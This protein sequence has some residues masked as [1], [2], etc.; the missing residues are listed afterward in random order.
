MGSLTERYS[1]GERRPLAG[2]G[3]L[4][5]AY[6]AC[7]AGGGALVRGRGRP[8]PERPS[9]PDLLLATIATHLASRLLAKDSVMAVVRSPFTRYERAT[10]EGEVQES[11]PGG[12]SVSHALGEL[13]TCPFCLAM[14]IATAV[15]FGLLLAPR[16]T[17]WAAATLCVAA[18][19]DYLQFAYAALQRRA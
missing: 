13:V 6:A 2:Y 12:T 17:R 15:S 3:A 10:G 9:G 18:G 7:V 11:V 8:L 4:L 16:A 19:S 5:G 1:H 14:W